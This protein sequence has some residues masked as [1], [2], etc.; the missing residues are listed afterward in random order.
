MIFKSASSDGRLNT[1][2]FC[3]KKIVEARNALG[4]C[5]AAEHNFWFESKAFDCCYVARGLGSLSVNKNVGISV[6]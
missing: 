3:K 6:C 1:F 5:H 4:D 2:M